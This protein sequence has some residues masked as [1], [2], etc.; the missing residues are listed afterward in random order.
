MQ[1]LVGLLRF[2]RLLLGGRDRRRRG[3]LTRALRRL[4][5]LLRGPDSLSVPD[6]RNLPSFGQKFANLPSPLNTDIICE[7]P[8]IGS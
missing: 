8:R 5:R 1:V 2:G 6:S 7:R 3:L 4:L